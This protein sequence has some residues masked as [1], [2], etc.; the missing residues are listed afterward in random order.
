M[1]LRCQ[2][3]MVGAWKVL[4]DG[5]PSMRSDQHV[6]QDE[7]APRVLQQDEDVLWEQVQE[8]IPHMLKFNRKG[9][10]DSS[11]SSVGLLHLCS[12]MMMDISEAD[13]NRLFLEHDKDCDGGLNAAELFDAAKTHNFFKNLIRVV[14]AAAD[15]RVGKDYDYCRSTIENYVESEGGDEA[16]GITPISAD[17]A[18]HARRVQWQD[19]VLRRLLPKRRPQKE[20]WLI[21]GLAMPE[22]L[23]EK[24][25]GWLFHQQI[26]PTGDMVELSI[27]LLTQLFPE[28]PL[29]IDRHHGFV[30]GAE[31]V[32]HEANMLEKKAL[33]ALMD[34]RQHV[35]MP[36]EPSDTHHAISVI[37]GIPKQTDYKIAVIDFRIDPP[38]LPKRHREAARKTGRLAPLPTV[39]QI[40]QQEELEV[41]TASANFFAR[42]DCS[43]DI[44][45]LL[46]V[47]SA[48]A[49][50]CWPVLRSCFDSQVRM[51][52][53]GKFPNAL[54][55]LQL[56]RMWCG[57][58]L[59]GQAKLEPFLQLDLLHFGAEMGFSQS[60]RRLVDVLGVNAP[61]KLA[62][63]IV[64]NAIPGHMKGAVFEEAEESVR[65][66]WLHG[67]ASSGLPS[68]TAQFLQDH[69]VAASSSLITALT[70]GCFV[71]FNKKGAASLIDLP[72]D[73][74]SQ[75]FLQF[76][77]PRSLSARAMSQLGQ[78][79]QPVS[80]EELL[81]G[82]A[83][84][85]CWLAP[86]EAVD[87]RMLI[88]GA[89]AYTLIPE[90]AAVVG[91]TAIYFEVLS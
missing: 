36:C 81:Q 87:G 35:W 47:E 20:P 15:F 69:D 33:E 38:A 40:P 14:L 3:C 10:E 46:R 55:P 39:P 57:K 58:L 79:W 6:T 82:G 31:L 17:K 63:S 44:P 76:G 68:L 8:V 71:H 22:A 25:L 70:V 49:S 85:E 50:K 56:S 65:L 32:R 28:L 19:A 9:R 2:T 53:P 78:R 66:A 30:S 48:D 84:L 51:L 37:Q 26:L 13:L 16:A 60:A 54:R 74:P 7:S 43:K 64:G 77:L 72:S 41:L 27:D 5:C 18:L 80:E 29:Y 91:S 62:L 12:R 88:G 11:L 90:V 89:F 1:R 83:N 52:Q 75:S 42:I 45:V 34:A 86:G 73:Q 23:P 21:L 59:L 67:C 24:V 4:R 61:L